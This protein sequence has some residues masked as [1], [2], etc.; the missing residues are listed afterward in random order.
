[1]EMNIDGN[2]DKFNHLNAD[3]SDTIAEGFRD[4]IYSEKLFD[5]CN[6]EDISRITEALMDKVREGI[7][8]PIDFPKVEPY[9]PG[10]E[11]PVG[12]LCD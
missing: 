7:A 2:K 12:M 8:T 3:Q 1:M 11:I 6:D 5:T 4:F 10:T 9:W